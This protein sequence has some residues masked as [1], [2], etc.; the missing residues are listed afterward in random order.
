[1]EGLEME[2]AGFFMA[3]LSTSR[4]NGIF[5]GHLVSFSSI[6]QVVPRKI[7]HLAEE[8]EDSHLDVGV[9]DE[10]APGDVVDHHPAH[11]GRRRQLLEQGC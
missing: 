10:V 2:D 11:V 9:D 8:S 6:W 5:Y 3:I 7:L 1:M 4:P